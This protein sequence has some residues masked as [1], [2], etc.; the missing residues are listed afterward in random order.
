M[1]V[2]THASYMSMLNHTMANK[3]NFDLYNFQAVTGLRSSS[4]S[5]YGMQAY[6]L[7]S[8]EASLNVN[9][10]FLE[11]NKILTTETNAMNT[12]LEAISKA[13]NDYKNMVTSFNGS[14]LDQITPDYTGGE[15][16]FANDDVTAYEGQTITINDEQY[17]FTD[18]DSTGNNIDINGLASGED[19]MNALKTKLEAADP[20]QMVDFKFE[21]NKVSFPLYT[22]NGSSSVLNVKGVETGEPHIMH[23]DQY[24]EMH[25]LQTTAF[26]TMKVLADSLNTMVNGKYLFGGGTSDKPPVDFPFKSL[27]EFQEYFDGN[28]IEYPTNAGSLLSNR[29]TG[30]D[31]T[32]DLTLES[33]GGNQGVIKADKDGGFLK[34][35]VVSGENTTGDLIFNSDTNQIKATEYGAFGT[36]NPGDTIVIQDGDSDTNGSYVIKSISEDGKTITV[37]DSTPIKA[38][39]TLA[40]GGGS[41]ISTS[42]P[43]GSVIEMDG[44]DNNISSTVQVTGVSPDG[45]ELYVTVDPSRWPEKG[46]SVNVPA[47][48]KW[49]MGCDSYYQGGDLSSEKRVNENQTIVMDVLAKDP[50]F[51]KMFRALGQIAQGNMV[52]MRDPAEDIDGLIDSSKATDRVAEAMDLIYESLFSGGNAAGSKNADL[53]SVQNK[54]NSQSIIIKTADDNLKLVI[55]NLETGIGSIKNVDKEE[56]AVKALLAK[57]TL[58]ASYSVLKSAM[59]ISLLN[60]LK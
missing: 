4:Y 58:D 34:E 30:A 47:S 13:M 55:N 20:T 9:E 17:T 24:R 32:G 40:N 21:G 14:D 7:V 19:V 37:E 50:A 35:A 2:P 45:K 41:T 39:K 28:N 48:S 8:L 1:R 6:S 27:E 12:A 59:S 56:A 38:D 3:S 36:L 29:V 16:S 51:E 25:E 49:Q 11:T 52:D 46:T 60:Y 18:G 44:F 15:I 43:V 26:A 22:V 10:S 53:Y 31:E 23:D 57:T 33:L 54:L 42:Y 5:G